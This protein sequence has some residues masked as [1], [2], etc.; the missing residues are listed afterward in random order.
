MSELVALNSQVNTEN[1]ISFAAIGGGF[2]PDRQSETNGITAIDCSV[3]ASH[4]LSG[5]AIGA[6]LNLGKQVTDTTAVN[7]SVTGHFANI[8]QAGGSGKVKGTASLNS[9]VN[10]ELKNIGNVT[11]PGLCR[12]ADARFVTS[13]CQ[14]NPDSF[15]EDHWN[16]S[17]SPAPPGSV[18]Q[19]IGAPVNKTTVM[20]DT[21][22]QQPAMANTTSPQSSPTLTT[23]APP[24]EMV[25]S[26]TTITGHTIT[27]SLPTI[28]PTITTTAPLAMAAM[29]TTA[30]VT[31]TVVTLPE[32]SMTV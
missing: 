3:S 21:T 17:S 7:S 19:P 27:T 6:G 23:P 2:L 20:A 5:G 8:S 31:E 26:N 25:M 15:T 4:N 10:G 11:L 16:C 1:A 13:D 30:P 18:S 28:N 9:R 32:A 29:T 22:P 14:L 24:S 12:T